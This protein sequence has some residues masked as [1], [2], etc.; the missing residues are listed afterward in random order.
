MRFS[1]SVLNLY[2]VVSSYAKTIFE[3][4][5]IKQTQVKFGFWTI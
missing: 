5:I 2:V 3:M 1:I 4:I